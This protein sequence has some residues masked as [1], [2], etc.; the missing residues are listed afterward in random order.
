[1][2]VKVQVPLF[3][4]QASVVQLLSSLQTMG[5]AA[6]QLPEEGSQERGVQKLVISGVQLT[7]FPVAGL[8]HAV[9]LE[10]SVNTQPVVAPQESIVH[11]LSS[12]H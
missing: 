11:A 2:G 5:G 7:I 12:L 3:V 1:M 4:R 6:T 10:T 8:S 9:Q